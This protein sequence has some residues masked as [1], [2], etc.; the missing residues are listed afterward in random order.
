MNI[1]YSL[2]HDIGYSSQIGTDYLRNLAVSSNMYTFAASKL[3]K[4]NNSMMKL[5]PFNINDAFT[6]LRLS[7]NTP[8]VILIPV[9]TPKSEGMLILAPAQNR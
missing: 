9:G 6:I 4:T 1:V 5:R 2:H 7:Q 8:R 3:I